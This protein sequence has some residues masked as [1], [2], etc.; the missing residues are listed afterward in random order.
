MDAAAKKIKGKG[1]IRRPFSLD[2]TSRFT[3]NISE[4][5]KMG[6]YDGILICTDIDGT[7]TYESGKVSEENLRAIEYF[8]SEG[9]IFTISSGRNP[10][11]VL[12][13]NVPVSAPII[14][15]NGS[16]I[17]SSQSGKIIRET[18]LPGEAFPVIKEAYHLFRDKVNYLKCF[19]KSKE[20]S[21]ES[22]DESF[23]E[24]SENVYKAVFFAKSEEDALLIRDYIIENSNGDYDVSRSWETGVEVI[25]KNGN[26]GSA[27]LFLKEYLGAKTYIAIGDFE[28]DISMLKA[29]DISYA[30]ENA[31][32][33]IKA[34]A[35]AIAPKKTGH[36]I[37]YIIEKI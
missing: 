30:V 2:K 19:S 13:L 12:D 7:L 31:S 29:A 20:Y 23:I 8:I 28:N 35:K 36:A 10:N 33:E 17:F 21:T 15:F 11:F 3:D 18:F 26:K 5:K 25:P 32:D 4:V 1:A 37:R 14:A 16:L 27:G 6:K 24:I 34:Y 9:G 22:D